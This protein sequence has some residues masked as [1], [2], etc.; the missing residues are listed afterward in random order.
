MLHTNSKKARENINA[1][2][3]EYA[4]DKFDSNQA[5]NINAVHQALYEELGWYIAR[6][7]EYNAVIHWVYGLGF[8]NILNAR[9]EV[10]KWLE[11]TEEEAAKYDYYE[12]EKLYAHLIARELLRPKKPS[13]VKENYE[14]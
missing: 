2:I 6:H 7:G 8:G 5:A 13:Y 14:N 9:E 3:Q 1:S 10:M 4:I 11:Q 12:T